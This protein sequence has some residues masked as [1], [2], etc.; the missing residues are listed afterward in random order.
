VPQRRE[1]AAKGRLV[2]VAASG[3]E[4]KLS[5]MI[6]KNVEKWGLSRHIFGP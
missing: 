1:V 6:K 5:K 2:D 4:G 3:A